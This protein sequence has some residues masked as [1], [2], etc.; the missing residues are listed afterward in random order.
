M[1][2]PWLK[3]F[4]IAILLASPACSQSTPGSS[5]ATLGSSQATLTNTGEPMRVEFACAEDEILRSGLD[6][7]D[8][9]PCPIYLELSVVARNGRKI[10]AVGNLH[11]TSV[12]LSS[13]LLA[14]ADNGAS[15]REPSPRIPGASLDALQFYDLE[16]G[17]AAGETQDPLARDP[18]FLVTTSGGD[19]WRSE[20]V[21]S[22]GM[23]GSI[24]WFHFDSAQH[25]DLAIDTGQTARSGR[26][27]T[28]ESQ[29][30]GASWMIRGTSGQQPKPK[31]TLQ[32]P[33]LR[34]HPVDDGKVWQLQE[35][36]GDNWSTVASFFVQS[37]S[38][39]SPKAK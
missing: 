14:S 7:S 5:Q 24:L 17:W 34:I 39:G 12:T 28:L 29:T 9:Q 20:P 25:G 2:F 3:L 26:Y 35:Q 32:D 37:A 13:L 11:A 6:C 15:W 36:N 18:F 22:E 19:T 30:G 23:P 1:T 10:F 33:G 27:S 8:D 21:N 31:G 16:H 4:P 38:C